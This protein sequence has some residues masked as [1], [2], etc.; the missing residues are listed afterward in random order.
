MLNSRVYRTTRFDYMHVMTDALSPPSAAGC[1]QA[2]RHAAGADPDK[3]RQILDGA[4][5]MFL[6][7]GFDAAS[8][9]SICKAAGVSKGTLYVYFENKVDLFV[10]LIE[11]RREDF[12]LSLHEEL[13]GAGSLEERLLTY[14]RGLLRKLTSDHVIRL[15]RIVI[16][17]SERMP[18]LGQRFYQAGSTYFLG[19]LKQSLQEEVEA[20]TLR[21]DDM[22]IAAVQFVELA[23]AGVWRARLFGARTYPPE[24]EEI[25]R[26]AQYAVGTFLASYRA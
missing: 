6:E 21:I 1:D 18:E 2:R 16:G 14:A 20:G 19:K 22:E 11:D 5:N 3:R 17:V 10:A 4:C 7:L 8:M 26:L 12:Y 9:N 25:D 23:T 15:Q 24:A 13:V